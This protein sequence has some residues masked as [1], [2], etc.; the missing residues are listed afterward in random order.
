MTR[1][2]RERRRE[3]RW[4][5]ECRLTWRSFIDLTATAL[6][7]RREVLAKVLKGSRLLRSEPLPGTPEEIEKAVRE[8]HLEGVVAKRRNSRYEPGK[9]S[10][11]WVKVKFNRRQEF[12]VGGF[13]P[14]ANA[15]ESLL[16]RCYEGRK[17]MFASKV[18]AG[19]T[20]HIRAELFPALKATVQAHCPFANLPSSK[21]GHWGEGITAG[22]MAAL[23][24]VKLR[25]GLRDHGVLGSRIFQVEQE[26]R[27]AC[28]LFD[29]ECAVVVPLYRGCAAA[30]VAPLV[31]F[32]ARGYHVRMVFGGA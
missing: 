17:L 5:R 4:N 13:K 22:D 27:H 19:L 7:E 1:P 24:W 10:R 11:A 23:R 30:G 14:N 20:P 9:R 3:A 8:L 16:V 18:R 12:V 6:D 32:R 31:A 21:T 28:A 29:G 26:Q 2:S 25:D 15:F